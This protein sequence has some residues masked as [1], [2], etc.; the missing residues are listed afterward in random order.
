MRHLKV[1]TTVNALRFNYDTFSTKSSQYLTI[2]RDFWIT[3]ER[4]NTL[5]INLRDHISRRNFAS[6]EDLTS[7]PWN[8]YPMLSL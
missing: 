2:A 6:A 7:D 3:G 8:T 4:Q 5:K 1:G